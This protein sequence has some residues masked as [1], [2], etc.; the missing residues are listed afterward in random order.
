MKTLLLAKLFGLALFIL[1]LGI[2]LIIVLRKDKKA[3]IK[4]IEEDGCPK[5]EVTNN[6]I[7]HKVGRIR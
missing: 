5:F 7:T 3:T 6:G 4:K 1:Y 2:C